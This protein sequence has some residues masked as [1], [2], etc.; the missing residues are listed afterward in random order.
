VFKV[1]Q[2]SKYSISRLLHAT[3]INGLPNPKVKGHQ[4]METCHDIY[5]LYITVQQQSSQNPPSGHGQA[6]H[7]DRMG[8]PLTMD[9]AVEETS[10][11]SMVVRMLDGQMG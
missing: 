1:Y 7:P 11:S 3:S 5:P 6:T 2:K 10:A 4:P 9:E 8:R